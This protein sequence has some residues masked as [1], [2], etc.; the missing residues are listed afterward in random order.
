[1]GRL[2]NTIILPIDSSHGEL[3][4]NSYFS[5]EIPFKN[6]KNRSDIPDAFI[7]QSIKDLLKTKEKILFISQDKG[8]IKRI[9]S[10]QIVCFESL[11]KLFLTGEYEIKDDFFQKLEQDDKT[12][13]L[14]RYFS[15]DIQRKA[16]YEIELSFVLMDIEEELEDIVIGKFIAVSSTVE[17][18]TFDEKNIKKTSKN[19]YLLPFS[20][21]VTHSVESET[22]KDDLSLINEENTRDIEKKVNDEGLFEIT[23]SIKDI[24]QGHLSIVFDSSNPLLWKEKVDGHGFFEKRDIKEIVISLEDMEK[25]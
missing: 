10:D 6:L 1:M 4:M 8:F 25:A 13:F 17:V 19:T 9:N 14:F 2:T 23:E 16:I 21:T 5:G 11:S 18:I 22:N 12:V 24:F 15:D 7:Y 20:T 3:V